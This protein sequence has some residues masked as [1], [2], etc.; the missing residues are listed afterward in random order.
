MEEIRHQPEQFPRRILLAL[1]G[2]SP[3][4]VTETLYF[5]CVRREP[6]FV[7][8]EVHLLTTTIG[9]TE[10]ID[11]LLDHDGAFHDFIRDYGF[12][13]KITFTTEHLHPLLDN[14]GAALT[15][16]RT[17]A[18]NIAA[19]DVITEK[20]R[21]LTADQNCAL[22][23]SI[24]GGRNTL[25]FYLGY[26]LSMFGRPQDR[27]SHVLVAWQFQGNEHFYYPPPQPEVIPGRN[28]K[29][30]N[31]READVTLAEIPFVSLRHGL[32]QALLDGRASYSQTVVAIRRALAP[33]S[34]RIDRKLRRIWC[35]ERPVDLPPQLFAFYVWMAERRQRGEA[36]GGH[37]T[38]RDAYIAREFLKVYLGVLGN[39]T[40]DFEETANTLKDGMT[41]EFFNEKKARVN[42]WL[43]EELGAGATAYLIVSSGKRPR[44]RFGLALA[45]EAIEISFQ[46]HVQQ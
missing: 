15:D 46:H 12:A 44:T 26:A 17:E 28:G 19:A 36:H 8:T 45:A 37:V 39:M 4:V 20:V 5:L 42:R 2:M 13:D 27:L 22:H 1:G 7:P 24:A 3:Q 31:T 21:E 43:K 23:V 14:D 32:P 30:L 9:H 6:P 25:G 35:S 33:P 16:V 40:H 18:D 11:G 38:W 34:L 10:A 41:E 29:P